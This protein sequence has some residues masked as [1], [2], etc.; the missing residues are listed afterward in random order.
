MNNEST[1][2]HSSVIAKSNLSIKPSIFH[3]DAASLEPQSSAK[4]AFQCQ[5][6]S[7]LSSPHVLKKEGLIEELTQS[8]ME[9]GADLSVHSLTNDS[10]Y[11]LKYPAPFNNTAHSEILHKEGD[12]NEIV[13]ISV[14]DKN[15]YEDGISSMNRHLQ[16]RKITSIRKDKDA[17]F[18]HVNRHNTDG[19]PRSFTELSNSKAKRTVDT[20]DK[21]NIAPNGVIHAALNESS[22]DRDPC[23]DGSRITVHP[24]DADFNEG[25]LNKMKIRYEEFQEH[26]AEVTSINQQTTHYKFFPSVV[27][28][29]CLNRPQKAAPMACVLKQPKRH[30]RLKLAKKLKAN[31]SKQSADIKRE[32][33]HQEC[34]EHNRQADLSLEEH[35]V[36]NENV[37]CSDSQ[38]TSN[39]SN[40]DLIK[41]SSYAPGNACSKS[42][43][44]VDRVPSCD[45][46]VIMDG[47]AFQ[48]NT[49]EA[50]SYECPFEEGSAS[51]DPSLALYGG[52]YT[53]RTKRKVN[54]ESEDGD[55]NLAANGSNANLPQPTEANEY[56]VMS[57][58][59]RKR[60]KVSKLPP[61][62]IKYIIINRFKGRKNMK[63]KLQ[64]IDSSEQQVTLT[65]EKI[66][67][68]NTMAPLKDFWPKVPDSPA[69]K[70][71]LFPTTPKKNSKRKT[72][73]KSAKKK[74]GRVPKSERNVLKQSLP[75]R[76]RRH[77]TFLTPPLPTYND[78]AKDCDTEFK[79]V[80]SKLGFLTDRSPSPLTMSPPRCWSP[81]D[82]RAEEI[83]ANQVEETALFKSHPLSCG[84]KE[85]VSS[86]KRS[87]RPQTKSRKKL[88]IS[89]Q[90]AK[91]GNKLNQTELVKD[92]KRQKGK[93]RQKKS[94]KAPRKHTK[95]KDWDK[96]GNDEMVAL[97]PEVQEQPVTPIDEDATSNYSSQ[98]SEIS[99]SG[100]STGHVHS[101]QLESSDTQAHS[102]DSKPCSFMATLSQTCAVQ[103]DSKSLS[104]PLLPNANT[105]QFKINTLGSQFPNVFQVKESKT[106]QNAIPKSFSRTSQV[107]QSA[108]F[109]LNSPF[110]QEDPT[111]VQKRL[112]ASVGKLRDTQNVP[113]SMPFEKLQSKLLPCTMNSQQQLTGLQDST[114]QSDSSCSLESPFSKSSLVTSLR[115][116]IKILSWKEKGELF[117]GT[118]F[119]SQKLSQNF[120]PNIFSGTKTLQNST[121]AGSSKGLLDVQSGIAVLKEL[122]HQKQKKIQATAERSLSKPKSSQSNQTEE[123]C[124]NMKSQPA[125]PNK[126]TRPPRSTKPKAVKNLKMDLIKHQSDQQM[127]SSTSDG[128]PGIFSDP[129]FESCYSLEDSLSPE[130]AYFDIN[131]VG[132]CSS[133]TGSQFISADQNLPQKF[134]S[135]PVPT[136]AVDQ[137]SVKQESPETE[138]KNICSL[139]RKVLI[140]PSSLSPDLFEKSSVDIKISP[141]FSLWKNGLL[142][143]KFNTPCSTSFTQQSETSDGNK[144]RISK[145]G[146]LKEASFIAPRSE[147]AFTEMHTQTKESTS[148]TC[149]HPNSNSSFTALASS[150]ETDFID[151]DLELFISRHSDGLTA[152]PYSSPRSICSPSQSKNGSATPRPVHILKPLMSPPSREEIMATLLDHDLMETVYQEPYFSNPS[153]APEKPR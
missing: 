7:A 138:E 58:K 40:I 96:R 16:C 9:K 62:I 112:L 153:D 117:D 128:N 59:S 32:E 26:K 149:S 75:P 123:K 68:Y 20:S 102:P 118:E 35:T 14:S 67:F 30:S 115:S 85:N 80:M 137:D 89:P 144:R 90:V 60:R 41:D 132:L 34:M 25:S 108:Q 86:K 5:Q 77:Q 3:K 70:Y 21:C 119:S 121:K 133:Y 97:V 39:L 57:P 53:L 71:P 135:D 76:R 1:L 23:V 61:I 43:P 38:S 42:P 129:E 126:K 55:S 107:I 110:V 84:K 148:D 69:T 114:K 28:S 13:T 95:I 100:F 99:L 103:K 54:F 15:V 63:I 145:P 136:Q 49:C 130:H 36:K 64:K 27:L 93:P 72:K 111:E 124:I 19:T 22:G 125:T 33:D 6:T 4:T 10:T 94:E 98:P 18:L 46:D 29:N 37:D 24:M 81:S 141:P 50:S 151:G 109:I 66:K 79:D 44:D 152:T 116:P 104:V 73:P 88:A 87:R 12:L 101:T 56:V 48:G 78:D 83:L 143:Q 11:S 74:T 82:P 113:D 146:L 2:T 134:L 147:W 8:P 91:L 52:K 120:L 105:E 140:R 47:G 17:S 131:S 45:M 65:D 92:G 106:A 127:K 31:I 142:T 122:L 139:D 51:L 150:P